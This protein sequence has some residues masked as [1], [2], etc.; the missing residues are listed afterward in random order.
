M[1]LT[2]AHS[3]NSANTTALRGRA[4]RRAA[5]IGGASAL[6]LTI[7]GPAFAQDGGGKGG[8]TRNL[9]AGGAGGAGPDGQDGADGT[10]RPDPGP[11]WR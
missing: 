3:G 8:D 5:L 11:H 6:A 10:V 9:A 7:A 4:L 1:G 2:V